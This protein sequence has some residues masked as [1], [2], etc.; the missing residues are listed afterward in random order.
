MVSRAARKAM[1]KKVFEE[2]MMDEFSAERGTGLSRKERREMARLKSK[3]IA[4]SLASY[5][6]NAEKVGAS[7][8]E[9]ELVRAPQLEVKEEDAPNAN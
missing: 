7:K 8:A 1:E 5:Q 6:E 9:A 3:V 2:L 4:R